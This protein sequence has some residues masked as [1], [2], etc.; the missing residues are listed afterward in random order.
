MRLS[1]TLSN[2]SAGSFTL[3]AWPSVWNWILRPL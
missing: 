2:S 1:A 3:R